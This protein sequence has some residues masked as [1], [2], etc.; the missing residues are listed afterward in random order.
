VVDRGPAH[1]PPRDERR[2]REDPHGPRGAAAGHAG[3][4]QGLRPG[5]VGARTEAVPEAQA[6]R[7][8]ATR[9]QHPRLHGRRR[10]QAQSDQGHADPGAGT[11]PRRHPFVAAEPGPVGDGRVERHV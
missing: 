1:W 5:R 7:Q 9:D 6:A 2:Q 8:D 4:I 10:A 11:G 3:D